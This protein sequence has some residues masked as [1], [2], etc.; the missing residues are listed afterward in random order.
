M[1]RDY[2][3]E[4]DSLEHVYISSGSATSSRCPR[5]IRT[6]SATIRTQ[7]SARTTRPGGSAP[8][9]TC[10]PI[11]WHSNRWTISEERSSA[12]ATSGHSPRYPDESAYSSTGISDCRRKTGPSVNCG[13]PAQAARNRAAH[14][15]E[16]METAIMAVVTTILVGLALGRLTQALIRG[17]SDPDKGNQ[18][19]IRNH[20]HAGDE[21]A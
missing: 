18:P 1:A 12:Y 2:R 19:G 21:A 6:S 14:K 11:T 13:W 8:A 5:A 9:N 7:S 17:K 20:T 15:G 3:K 10:A 4:R 16:T